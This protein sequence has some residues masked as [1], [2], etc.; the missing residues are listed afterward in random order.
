M[1]GWVL[2][3]PFGVHRCLCSDLTLASVQQKP[4]QDEW[5]S[6]L[7]AFQ[8]ALQMEEAVNEALLDLH[9]LA[10]EKEDPHV[11]EL[12]GG[13]KLVESKGG[14]EKGARGSPQG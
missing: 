6:S 10:M 2:G 3:Q 7:E 4:E 13:V 11:G 5:G 1:A 9:K 8:N 14:P 12:G